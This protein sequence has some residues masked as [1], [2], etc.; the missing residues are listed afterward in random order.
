MTGKTP[1]WQWQF[2]TAPAAKH[3]AGMQR[4]SFSDIADWRNDDHAAALA[5][6]RTSWNAATTEAGLASAGDAAE[7]LAPG[8]TPDNARAFFETFF[9]PHFISAPADGGLVTGYFE[10]ELAGSLTASDEY[11]VPVYACPD[12][13]ILLAETGGGGSLPP[14]ATAGRMTAEGLAPYF[15]R[16]DIEQGALSGRSLEIA[17]LADPYDAYVMQIQGSALIRLSN[18]G[19]MRVGF[20]GKNGHPYSSVG[21]I[22]IERGALD[23][24]AA[25]MDT[26]MGWLRANPVEGRAVMRANR[27]YPFFRRLSETESRNGP[28][29][30][31]GVALTPGRSLAVDPRYHTYGW[32]IWVSAPSLP[33]GQGAPFERL[34]IAQDSGSAIRGPVRG[35]IF[36]GTGAD[37][38]RRAGHTKNACNFI[39]LIPN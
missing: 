18:G 12:D 13:L 39:V 30:S 10:P 9:T 36:W 20:D 27:S 14:G 11:P 35:D 23:G 31:M 4:I 19:T 6:F 15:T 17:Y 2:G 34:M 33:D 1:L 8:L 24:S 5:A 26:V 25:S 37:A 22:L 3:P 21:K 28:V 16:Q 38:G 29:G 32:P 7:K